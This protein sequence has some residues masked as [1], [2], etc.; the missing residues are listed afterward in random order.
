[1]FILRAPASNKAPASIW[2]NVCVVC[3]K[4]RS[5]DRIASLDETD[6]VAEKHEADVVIQQIRVEFGMNSDLIGNESEFGDFCG[7]PIALG[8]RHR[9][10]GEIVS[11]AV[12][13]MTGSEHPM[14]I[15]NSRGRG[16]ALHPRQK[17]PR[18]FFLD[19][20]AAD[21]PRHRCEI[22]VETG[23]GEARADSQLVGDHFLFPF[24]FAAFWRFD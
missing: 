15:E 13:D 20:R 10:F 4:T 8:E 21:Q 12:A 19:D 14:D 6:D 11:S 2:H 17:R 24:L 23:F 1:V 16:H 9:Q 22:V 7:R 3:W 18:P 5:T